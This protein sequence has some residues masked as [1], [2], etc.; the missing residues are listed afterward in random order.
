MDDTESCMRCGREFQGGLRYVVKVEMFADVPTASE[1]FRARDVT[2]ADVEGWLAQVE[3]SSE[4]EL[5]AQVHEQ[6]HLL[7]CKRCR[8]Q[9]GSWLKRVESE[10][11]PGSHHQL[12]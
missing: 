12:H 2:P 11:P 4:E 6:L 3:A 9:L 1:E 10:Q 8:D 5:N 7:M